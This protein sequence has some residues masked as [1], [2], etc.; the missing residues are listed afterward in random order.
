MKLFTG[1]N[2]FVEKMTY[3]TLHSYT[4]G[5]RKRYTTKGVRT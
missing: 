5:V 3:S 4:S 1:L 2:K